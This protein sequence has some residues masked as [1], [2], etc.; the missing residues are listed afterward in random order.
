MSGIATVMKYIRKY[1]HH[2]LG[3]KSFS[4]TNPLP[5]KAATIWGHFDAAME[6]TALASSALDIF[7][8]DKYETDFANATEWQI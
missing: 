2:K 6:V 4:E 5:A 1:F 8:A 7:F 3:K